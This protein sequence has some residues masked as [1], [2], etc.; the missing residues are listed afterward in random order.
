MSRAST[1]FMH[2]GVSFTINLSK[3]RE[4][5]QK[6]YQKW[7]LRWVYVILEASVPCISQQ[8]NTVIP[9]N[10]T[11]ARLVWAPLILCELAQINFHI[12]LLTAMNTH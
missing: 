9:Q 11:A 12:N 8:E 2:L 6:F 7:K 5:S 10:A 3:D 1:L 4:L